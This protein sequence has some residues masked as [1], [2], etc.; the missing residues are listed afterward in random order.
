MHTKSSFMRV[1]SLFAGCGGLDL[2]LIKSGHKIV[3]ATDNDKDCKKTYG[4]LPLNS[5]SYR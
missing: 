4:K 1:V 2:G 3:L 5:N